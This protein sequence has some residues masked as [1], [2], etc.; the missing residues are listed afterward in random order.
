M[1]KQELAS[2]IETYGGDLYSFCRYLT[3]DRTEADELYQDTWLKVLELSGRVDSDRNIKGYCLSVALKL[4]KNRKRKFAWRKRIAPV[5]TLTDETDAAYPDG[6]TSS[7]DAVL[8]REE[9]FLIRQAVNELPEKLKTVILL[10]YMEEMSLAQIAEMT[11]VSYGT[12]KSRL[13]HA[14]Q[15][16]KKRWE[17]MS[18]ET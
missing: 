11:H 18:D 4:W 13:Y 1:T 3:R 2:Y 14:R 16:L 5:R 10:H 12:V 8:R 6:A 17:E 7:E 9:I 15:Y